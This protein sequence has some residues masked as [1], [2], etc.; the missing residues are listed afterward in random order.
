[1]EQ[2]A[3]GAVDDVY[4]LAN[5][6]E[7]VKQDLNAIEEEKKQKNET[8]NSANVVAQVNALVEEMKGEDAQRKLNN[9]QNPQ[10]SLE[11]S[12][13]QQLHQAQQALQL[14][15]YDSE[16][17][18]SNPNVNTQLN[19]N[20]SSG[21]SDSYDDEEDS[22]GSGDDSHSS[23]ENDPEESQ[24]ALTPST[25]YFYSMETQHKDFVRSMV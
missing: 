8:D 1:M 23:T 9:R 7:E 20:M 13:L 15:S 5:D 17:D 2:S 22:Q 16:A 10:P 3:A 6:S 24:T 19:Q 4:E 12:K 25:E 21:G 11:E 14:S 18:K